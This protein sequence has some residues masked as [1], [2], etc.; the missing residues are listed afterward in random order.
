[1]A[2]QVIDFLAYAKQE[3]A[4]QQVALNLAEEQARQVALYDLGVKRMAE[5]RAVYE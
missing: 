2:A 4:A 3:I 1:M 5:M